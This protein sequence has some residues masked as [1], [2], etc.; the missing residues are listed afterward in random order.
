MKQSM[1]DDPWAPLV[2]QMLGFLD[3]SEANRSFAAA[4]Q[5]PP[6]GA[7]MDAAG[8]VGTSN[9]G[10]NSNNNINNEEE[11]DID[12]AG[13]SDAGDEEEDEE[14]HSG[15]AATSGGQG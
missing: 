5:L 2:Q 4:P 9:G 3:P 10:S 13:A 12:D 15:E 14:P 7:A 6:H 11:I 1:L 8:A